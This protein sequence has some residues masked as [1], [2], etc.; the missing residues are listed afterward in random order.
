MTDP[1]TPDVEAILAERL[2]EA[3]P[4]ERVVDVLEPDKGFPQIVI[5]LV[6]GVWDRRTPVPI[7][8]GGRVQVDVYGDS[9]AQAHDLARSAEF[10]LL[11]AA[12]AFAF[13]SITGVESSLSLRW[14]P[15]LESG[16]ARYTFEV[17]V[18]ARAVT[19]SP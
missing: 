13:G 3:P 14:N 11:T 12:G 9:K 19:T 1:T 10:R 18:Y 2:Q 8:L 4:L 7:L 15:E 5:A 17:R 6:G 16:R